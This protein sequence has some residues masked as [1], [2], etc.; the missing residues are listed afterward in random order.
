MFKRLKKSVIDKNKLL[1]TNLSNKRVNK[2]PS[3]S[4]FPNRTN[5]TFANIIVNMNSTP[6]FNSIDSWN[7]SYFNTELNSNSFSKKL[8][9]KNFNDISRNTSETKDDHSDILSIIINGILCL[10]SNELLN[11]CTYLIEIIIYIRDKKEKYNYIDINSE[12]NKDL[13][14]I[15]YQIYFQIF[16]ENSFIDRIIRNDLKSGMKIFKKIHSIYILYILS[17]LS[18]SHEK[19]KSTKTQFYNFLKQFI[20]K[21]KCADLKCP[22]CIHAG[23]FDKNVSFIKKSSVI[24]IID[25]KNKKNTNI[26]NTRKKFEPKIKKNLLSI[27]N[28]NIINKSKIN[29]IIAKNYYSNKIN[30]C[31]KN[32][33]IFSLYK[34]INNIYDK[35]KKIFYSQIINADEKEKNKF[36]NQSSI[37]NKMRTSKIKFN[38]CTKIKKD[39]TNNTNNTVNNNSN[40]M[41]EIDIKRYNTE[42]N[43]NIDNKI[44]K[45]EGKFIEEIKT[46]LNK[47]NNSNNQIKMT[48]KKIKKPNK[49]VDLND[50]NNKILEIYKSN[51]NQIFKTKKIKINL[52]IDSKVK[53]EK[54]NNI[55]LNESEKK[56]IIDNNI[57]I[58]KKGIAQNH[59][60]INESSKIIK[61]NINL[62]EK[63]IN[64]FKEH[65]LFIKQQLEKIYNTNK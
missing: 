38:I 11:Y 33:K 8:F 40:N 49:T 29:N 64:A 2:T 14:M 43:E 19:L 61:A 18:Y 7:N 54:K 47:N 25:K 60:D 65:N 58:G 21:E 17:G 6:S 5:L 41:N 15:I 10:K 57:N 12:M 3:K 9:K 46:K 45:I 27:S 63:E 56:N 22:T 36:F 30:D 59:K 44:K 4:M 48:K 50:I 52:L 39:N 20:K 42:K 51:K 31:S 24:K 1:L 13:L 62:I 34:S 37:K 35:K 28:D 53:I 16:P 26:N 23:N 32:K 55:T